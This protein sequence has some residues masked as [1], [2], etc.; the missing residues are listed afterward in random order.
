MWVFKV[1]YDQST[2]SV[3]R[4]KARLVARGDSQQ[5]GINYDETYAPVARFASFRTLIAFAAH[6]DLDLEHVDITTAYYTAGS[7]KKSI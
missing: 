1:I 4:F 2:G 6:F 3:D 7:I 5:Y